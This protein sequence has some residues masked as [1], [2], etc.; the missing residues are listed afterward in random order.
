MASTLLQPG[1]N[2]F[3]ETVVKAELIQAYNDTDFGVEAAPPFLLKIGKS[4]ESL[5]RLFKKHQ[6]QSAAYITAWNPYSQAAAPEQNISSQSRLENEL[7]RR[8]LTY[9]PGMGA[10]SKGQYPGESSFLVLDISLETSKV[11]GRAYEQ[12][13]VVWCGPDAVPTLILLR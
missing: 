2:L 1:V 13:A 3:P 9:F 6:C 12:N 11:L 7:K 8:S 4:N 5:A 10:D